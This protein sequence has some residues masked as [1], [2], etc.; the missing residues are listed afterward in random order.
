MVFATALQEFEAVFFCGN[1]L[2][3]T[4]KSSLKISWVWFHSL[5]IG[6]PL[7]LLVARASIQYHLPSITENSQA[8]KGH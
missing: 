3:G 2:L 1:L 7:P 5:L 8:L 4:K 6:L